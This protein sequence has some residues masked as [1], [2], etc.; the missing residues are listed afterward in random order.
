M[1]NSLGSLGASFSSSDRL[2]S[3]F[4]M[5]GDSFLYQL[6]APGDHSIVVYKGVCLFRTTSFTTDFQEIC[7]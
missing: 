1:E 2:S 3:D 6:V 4:G 5:A 7:M